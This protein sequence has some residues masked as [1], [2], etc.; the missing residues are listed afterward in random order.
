MTTRFTWLTGAALVAAVSVWVGVP[1]H[2]AEG[3]EITG[4][5]TS[6]SGP[7]EGVWVIAETDDLPA[8]FIKTVV[9]G[10]GGRFLIPELP[11]RG[12]RSGSVGMAWQIRPRSTL[13]QVRISHSKP[14]W[15]PMMSRQPRSIRPTIGTR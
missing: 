11:P 5:V 10:D 13:S 7:E 4:V 6:A 14:G 9:T 12:T 8:R 15:P 3:D 1:G 2:A